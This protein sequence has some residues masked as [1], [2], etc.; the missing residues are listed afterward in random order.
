MENQ[1]KSLI[2]QL[3]NSLTQTADPK[4]RAL[5]EGLLTVYTQLGQKENIRL[6]NRLMNYLSFTAMTEKISFTEDQQ[7]LI[8]Q[9]NQISQKAG[10]NNTYRAPLGSKFSF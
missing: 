7:Q 8:R 3:Y 6:I 5:R 9:L 1:S 4:T 10:V 2:H